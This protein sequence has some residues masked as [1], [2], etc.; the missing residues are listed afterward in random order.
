MQTREQYVLDTSIFTNP[1]AYEVFAPEPDL[2]LTSF[3]SL[4]GKCGADFFMPTS[5]YEELGKMRDLSDLQ[6]EFELTVKIRS[7]RRHA[8]QIPAHILY[9]FI[10]EIR[11]RIDRGLRIAEEHARLGTSS[12]REPGVLIASLRERYRDALRRGIIDSREDADVLLLAYE[13]DAALVTADEGLRTWADKVGVKLVTC[14]A[15]KHI[16]EHLAA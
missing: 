11:R 9:E 1:R 15:F 3:L 4:A 8:L 13:L 6:A 14:Q 12:D 16:L 5:V 10:E 2:A 7:P